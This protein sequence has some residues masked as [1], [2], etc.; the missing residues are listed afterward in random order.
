MGASSPQTRRSGRCD[1]TFSTGTRGQ[2]RLGMGDCILTDSLSERQRR[3]GL[4]GDLKLGHY[5][6]FSA[7]EVGFGGTRPVLGGDP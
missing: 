6:A 7:A 2:A 3:L 1:N 4:G 5:P